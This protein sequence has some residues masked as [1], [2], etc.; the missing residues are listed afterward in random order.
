MSDIWPN[1]RVVMQRTANPCMSV[2][3][4]FRP[5]S[6][7]GSSVVEQMTVNHLAAGSNPARGVDFIII[8]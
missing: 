4:R 5:L 7:L 1:G 8:F 2:R 3:F 6:F